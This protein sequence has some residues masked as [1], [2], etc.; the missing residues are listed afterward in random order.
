[1]ISGIGDFASVLMLVPDLIQVRNFR[2]ERP[3]NQV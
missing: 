2:A 1:M 3:S